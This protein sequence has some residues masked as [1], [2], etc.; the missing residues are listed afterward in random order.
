MRFLKK[1]IIAALHHDLS[2]SKHPRKYSL[3]KS[4][5]KSSQ[6]H[7]RQ[8]KK[9]SSSK[10]TRSKGDAIFAKNIVK[11]YG[12]AMSAFAASKFC[13]PYLKDLAKKEGVDEN[14]FL[15]FIATYKESVDSIDSLRALLILYED[16]SKDLVGFKKVFRGLCEIFLK[17]FSVNWIFNGKMHHKLQHLKYRHKMLRRIRNP[18]MFTYLT[19]KIK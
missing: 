13:F 19:S 15:N 11:N 9:I 3:S 2:Q 6:R 1:R 10:S 5:P 14:K 12:K 16:D 7:F 18:E 17:Y 4:K 8:K